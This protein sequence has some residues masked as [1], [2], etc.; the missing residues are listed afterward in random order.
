MVQKNCEQFVSYNDVLSETKQIQHGVPQ[1]SILGLILYL[2]DFSRA[3]DTLFSILFSD[4][5][6]VLIEGYSYN[7]IIALLNNELLKI[8]TWLQSNKLNINKTHYMI[9]HRAG[10][11]PIIDVF[12]RQD[13]VSLTKSTQFLGIRIDNKLYIN[14]LKQETTLIKRH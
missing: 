5:I 2:Y 12:I 8:D 11:K 14:Y 9:F 1:G 3:S 7:N 4:D 6:T 13:K 10:L